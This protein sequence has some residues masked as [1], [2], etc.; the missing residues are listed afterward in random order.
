MDYRKLEKAVDLKVH[1]KTPS[2][3]VLIDQET[4]QVYEGNEKYA[5]KEDHNGWKEIKGREKY[6]LPAI[7]KFV[8]DWWRDLP[9]PKE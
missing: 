5:N 9:E 8:S 1:T 7:Q 2:K 6:D 4:N 3:W